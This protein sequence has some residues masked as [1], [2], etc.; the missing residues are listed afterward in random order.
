M[1]SERDTLIAELRKLASEAEAK[2][3]AN[4]HD[5]YRG[6]FRA[7]RDAARLAALTVVAT[8]GDE[9]REPTSIT[10]SDI[11]EANRTRVGRWHG[12]ADWSPL[13]WAGAMAGEAGEACNAAK[14]LK[15]IDGQVANI[16]TEPGRS[17]TNRDEACRKIGLEVADTVIYG[18]LL[19]QRVGVNLEDCIRE[20][21][22][23]KSEE[24]G[25]PER[26]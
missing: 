13:E 10:L 17:L 26:L 3:N 5:F 12:I 15:R 14:K 18:F 9:R 21:F 7:Y 25:F 19:A 22:N 23:R 11:A 16:N 1:S 4:P 8:P 2:Y 6:M 20:A 24:Y